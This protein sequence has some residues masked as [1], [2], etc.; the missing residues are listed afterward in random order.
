MSKIVLD[1]VTNSNNITKINE[2]FSK[3]ETELQDRVLYRDN[4]VGEP[5]SVNNNIDMNGNTLFNI[6][7][8]DVNSISINGVPIVPTGTIVSPIPTPI[9]QTGKFLKSDGVTSVWQLITNS[10]L[11]SLAVSYASSLIGWI[12]AGTGAVLRT[13]QDKFREQVSVKDYGVVGD[14]ITDDTVNINIANNAAL[15][16]GKSLFWPKG[17]YL[18]TNIPALAGMKWIG[19]S[20]LT[21]IIKTKN[22]TNTSL[23]TSASNSINDVFIK[24]IRFDGNSSNNTAG[25]TLTIK[26]SRTSLIDIVIINSANTGIVT[27]W[28]VADAARLT[29]C[30]GFFSHIT[31]D[32]SQGSGWIHSGPSDSHFESVIITDAGIKTNNTYY[33]MFLASGSGNGRFFDLH[34]WNRDTTTNVPT[35]ACYVQSSGNNFVGCHL[36]GGVTCISVTGAGNTFSSTSAYAPRGTYTVQALGSSNHYNLILGINA[37]SAN[38][39]Y[40]GV[41]LSGSNSTLHLVNAGTGCTL[42]AV[43]FTGDTGNNFIRLTGNQAS[44]V[45]YTGT[46]AANDDVS[47]VVGGAG[48][49]VLKQSYPTNWTTYTPT[50]S[51]GSGSITTSSATGR[52]MKIGKIVNI[53]IQV[54]ITTNGTGATSIIVGLPFTSASF[55][56]IL[57]GRE[58]GVSGK[59]LQGRIT[60]ATSIVDIFNYDNTYP[61]VDGS[62]IIISGV[63]ESAS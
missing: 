2:N 24:S 35:V 31:I 1:D 37:A 44:G 10:D 25:D 43:D 18:A 11:G 30:E 6:G 20:S 57:A 59:M 7:N 53:E 32:S 47:I 22:G 39:T 33:G 48:G 14:G 56:Y 4:L 29:A 12:Q 13:I 42:G 58:T 8:L 9:G 63:Y 19:E 28:N 15:V 16:L 34:T 50:V 38:P 49:G 26:G 45:P 61:A 62:I 46:P 21:T 54:T 52:Y 60:S 41:L 40:K 5:N 51:A 17:T 27:D 23:V 36:E 55:P 3:I